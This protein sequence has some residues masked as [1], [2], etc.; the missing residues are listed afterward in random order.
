MGSVALGRHGSLVQDARL[1]K[2][3]Q[4]SKML[5]T[6]IEKCLA[7]TETPVNALDAIAVSRGPGSYTGLRVGTSTAKGLCYG[8]DIPLIAIDTLMIIAYPFCNTRNAQ[9]EILIPLIDA[10]R[11]EVYCTVFDKTLKSLE[12]TDNKILGLESFEAYRHQRTIICG[13]GSEKAEEMINPEGFDFKTTFPQAR[14]MVGLAQATFEKRKFENLLT[15]EPFY[16]KPP[17]ITKPSKQ[18]LK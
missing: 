13:D 9:H 15:F 4:H 14:D 8:L 7:A 5:T 6:L 11:K 16:L 2:E 1:S 12:K 3:W 17:N 10:R 18:V